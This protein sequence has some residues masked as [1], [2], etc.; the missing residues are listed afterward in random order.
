MAV[1]NNCVHVSCD[2]C[3]KGY[4]YDSLVYAD[5]MFWS[6]KTHVGDETLDLCPNCSREWDRIV[7]NFLYEEIDISKGGN[8]DEPNQ[9]I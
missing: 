3:G 8:T 7:R 2:R 4:Y 1:T 5:N 9:S 6:F